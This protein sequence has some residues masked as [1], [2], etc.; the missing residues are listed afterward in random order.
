MS[1]QSGPWLGLLPPEV[2]L[3]W[4]LGSLT[5]LAADACVSIAGSSAGPGPL[6]HSSLRAGDFWCGWWLLQD[7][8]LGEQGCGSA[9][10]DCPL[11][12]VVSESLSP[13]WVQG[14]SPLN[15]SSM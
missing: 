4:V 5:G 10:S 1:L 11:G 15:M 13:A 3:A 8:R 2:Q 7:K 14:I 12:L 6:G 9:F